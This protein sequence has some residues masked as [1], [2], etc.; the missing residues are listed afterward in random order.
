MAIGGDGVAQMR[1][2]VWRWGF[3]ARFPLFGGRGF[4]L[5]S[6]RKYRP[7]FTERYTGQYGIRKQRYVHVGPWCFRTF[8][9]DK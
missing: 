3:W 4:G 2:M 7:V 9:P 6:H 8:G 5:L 1:V